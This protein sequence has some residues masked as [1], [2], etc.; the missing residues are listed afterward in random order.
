MDQTKVRRLLKAMDTE[1]RTLQ[2]TDP[3]TAVKNRPGRKLIL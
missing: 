1:I 3:A 2:V